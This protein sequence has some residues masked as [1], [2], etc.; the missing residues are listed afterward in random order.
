MSDLLC[1]TFELTIN[2]INLS[3]AIISLIFLANQSC[4][5]TYLN[6]FI[7]HLSCLPISW[8]ITTLYSCS[9]TKDASLLIWVAL[10]HIWVAYSSIMIIASS[11]PPKLFYCASELLR[12]VFELPTGVSY[13]YYESSFFLPCLPVLPSYW[14]LARLS[15]FITQLSCL[16]ALPTTIMNLA[17]SSTIKVA[18]LRI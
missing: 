16:P 15:C 13:W 1:Y 18:S 8:N 7:A 9:T 10:L 11:L 6:C 2:V 17:S 14:F 4:F 12:S 3:T 5:V